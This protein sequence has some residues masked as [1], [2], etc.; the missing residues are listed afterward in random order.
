MWQ[1]AFSKTET[2]MIRFENITKKFGPITALDDVSFEIKKGEVLG[3]LG[4]NGAGK[5]TAMRILTGFFPPSHGK[6]WFDGQDFEKNTELFKNRIG[7]LPE[8]VPLYSDLTVTDFLTFV[9]RVKQ[10]SDRQIKS[11]L[12]EIISDCG[13]QDVSRRVIG[14]L[15]K[16]YKQ[17]VGLAQAL[18]GKPELLILD[19]PTT[20][21][22]PKQIVE[23]RSLIQKLA[24]ERTVILSSH[25]LPE[26]SLICKRIVI[27][28]QGRIVASDSPDNLTRKL[29]KSHSIRFIVQGPLATIEQC[30][31][32][33]GGVRDIRLKPTHANLTEGVVATDLDR[34][35]RSEIVAHFVK[36]Q[37]QVYEIHGVKLSLE[38][39][40]VKLV[41]EENQV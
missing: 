9:A 40:F 7:Y 14:K 19:E 6:V 1:A 3:F 41:T 12:A 15:S 26:V 5:T 11:Q 18:V 30:L 29:L 17:R 23:I 16:G 22:D 21:L 2:I 36:N 13:L 34:D 33:I 8:M 24:G 38:D 20:G 25:I 35:L 4:P 32:S 37:V 10:V 31:K 28:N 27:I 39:I